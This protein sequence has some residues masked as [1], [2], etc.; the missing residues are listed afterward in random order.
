M[1]I[2][3]S[4]LVK[5][6]GCY[7]G[8]FYKPAEGQNNRWLAKVALATRQALHYVEQ[9]QYLQR[10]L[11]DR[12]DV[13]KIDFKPLG[14]QVVK[15]QGKEDWLTFGI[16]LFNTAGE[17]DL[18]F[19]SAKQLNSMGIGDHRRVFFKALGV[20]TSPALSE[21][22]PSSYAA[23][24]ARLKE[25]YH[26]TDLTCIREINIDPNTAVDTVEQDESG[27]FLFTFSV[28]LLQ[29]EPRQAHITGS[30]RA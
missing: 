2:S 24:L 23:L 30:F 9:R 29:Q 13:G 12:Q 16:R 14:L 7:S 22:P 8:L 6:G 19:R 21:L 15:F 26:V 20:D 4:S 17:P 27:F 1:S 10:L 25:V 5:V 3:A 18:Y 11:T 28:K